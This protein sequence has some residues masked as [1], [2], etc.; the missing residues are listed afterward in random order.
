MY[1]LWLECGVCPTAVAAAALLYTT[2]CTRHV[3][4]TVSLGWSLMKIPCIE[5]SNASVE[6]REMYQ[7]LQDNWGFVP[8]FYKVLAHSKDALPPVVA[9]VE[10]LGKLS[11][12]TR[13]A[14]LAY[15][16]VSVVNASHY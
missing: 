12:G 16:T 8:N 10:L 7:R 2:A 4:A 14:E 15:L 13:L 6:V 11:I 5:L 1:C 3:V 9:G